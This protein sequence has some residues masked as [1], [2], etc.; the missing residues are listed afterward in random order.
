MDPTTIDVE[1]A[2][3]L[4][5]TVA[6][7]VRDKTMD[8]AAIDRHRGSRIQSFQLLAGLGMGSQAREI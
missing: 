7:T 5:I 6:R 3:A 8:D 4:R 2:R 1:A